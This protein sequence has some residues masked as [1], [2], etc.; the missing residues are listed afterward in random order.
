MKRPVG[1]TLT[2]AWMSVLLV[3]IVGLAA[4]HGDPLR[5]GIAFVA[6]ASVASVVSGLWAGHTWAV[7]WFRGLLG[8]AAVLA[9]G[10]AIAALNG[11]SLPHSPAYYIARSLIMGAWLAYLLRP[12]VRAF[13]REV[14]APAVLRESIVS[15]QHRLGT[16]GTR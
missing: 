12:H 16:P 6:A 3:A 14:A 11:A 7:R 5:L 8:F 4:A 2:V 13:F 10:L 9:A 1:V 15:S